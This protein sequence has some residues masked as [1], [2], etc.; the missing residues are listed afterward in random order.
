M[1]HFPL[2]VNFHRNQRQGTPL[3]SCSH[4][5]LGTY[6]SSK[7]SLSAVAFDQSSGNMSNLHI[8]TLTSALN[9]ELK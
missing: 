7:D 8:L 3:C 1:P 5:H 2:L 4:I 9:Q 6:F